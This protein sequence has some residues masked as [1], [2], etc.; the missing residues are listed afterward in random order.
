MQCVK[1][2]VSS[3]CAVAACLFAAAGMRG[4]YLTE[5]PALKREQTESRERAAAERRWHRFNAKVR[6]IEAKLERLGVSIGPHKGEGGY[7]DFSRWRGSNHDLSLLGEFAEAADGDLVYPV[8][9]KLKGR[10]F[11]DES[12][13]YVLAA[14][15]VHGLELDETRITDE[16][17]RQLSPL[18]NSLSFLS[19]A[20]TEITD[21]GLECL[22]EFRLHSLDLSR[23]QIT[24]DGLE[25][26]KGLANLTSLRLGSTAINDQALAVVGKLPRLYYLD[27]RDTRITDE[28]LARLSELKLSTLD[29]R[30]TALTGQGLERLNCGSTLL[31]LFLGSTQIDDEHLKCLDRF[32][33]MDLDL[34]NTAITDEGLKF[35]A[36][37]THLSQLFLSGTRTTSAGRKHLE[38]TLPA[39]RTR[40]GAPDSW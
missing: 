38:K 31:R 32:R 21:A 24:T 12:L 5:G 40:R 4:F 14:K 33:F 13:P 16:G 9:I 37:W 15:Y 28:G 25:S 8:E 26:L 3:L 36:K 34:E 6:P 20:R 2:T 19:L 29:L 11:G 30:G 27:L 17:L 35:L 23:T 18:A 39:A 7:L 10:A 22:K 1:Y